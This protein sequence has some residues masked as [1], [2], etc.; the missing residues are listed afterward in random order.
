MII[1]HDEPQFDVIDIG[2]SGGM[3]V[4][5]A[6]ATACRTEHLLESR[7]R[8]ALEALAPVLALAG[9]A[10]VGLPRIVHRDPKPADPE[11]ERLAAEKRA[12]KATKLEAAAARGGIL[13]K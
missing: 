4:G 13:K 1:E 3:S 6:L 9:I 7:Y 10:G 2:Q 12:R 11:A 5:A 8:N